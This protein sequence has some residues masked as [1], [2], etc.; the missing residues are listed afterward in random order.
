MKTAAIIGISHYARHHLLMA[1]EQALQGRLRLV[2]AVVINLN[3]EAFFCA[4]LRSLGCAIFESTDAM[5]AVWAGRL[6]LCFIPTGIYLHAEMTLRALRAGASVL[7]E[8]PLATSVAEADAIMKAERETG[9]F[10]A[11]GF[12]DL[13]TETTWEIKRLLLEETIGRLRSI[14]IVGMWPRTTNYY[15]RNEWAG[16]LTHNGSLVLDSPVNNAFAHFLNLALFWA[17]PNLESSARVG[18]VEA[19]LYRAQPIESFDTCCVRAQ[20]GSSTELRFYATHSCVDDRVPRMSIEGSRGGIEWVQE[21]HYDLISPT[22][23]RTRH[24]IPAKF[25][26][27]LMMADAILARFDNPQARICGTAIAREHIRLVEAIHAAAPIVDVPVEYIRAEPAPA[28][29][30]RKIV[31]IEAAIDRAD[32]QRVLWSECEVAWAVRGVSA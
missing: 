23:T 18:R 9:R 14:A 22:G 19:E 15:T 3:Q 4:R 10:V 30:K 7:V 26:T 13:Y 8:K 2:A 20:L 6:D 27:K 11:V 1:M 16:R 31:A 17:G 28:G 24:P 25:E 29:E 32:A 5:W 12:Q 21:S